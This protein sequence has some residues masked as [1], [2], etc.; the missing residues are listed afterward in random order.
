MGGRGGYVLKFSFMVFLFVVQE[1]GG[2]GSVRRRNTLHVV[3]GREYILTSAV[4][5][6]REYF[7]K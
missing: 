4:Y 7:I 2:G 1:C 6:E 3:G 5:G